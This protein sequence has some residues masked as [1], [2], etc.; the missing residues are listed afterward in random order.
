MAEDNSKVLTPVARRT[1]A[2][3]TAL[4]AYIK[5]L[6]DQVALL[7]ADKNALVADLAEAKGI[8]DALFPEDAGG[9]TGNVI[10]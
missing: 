3:V 2:G 7:T 9:S 5:K 1:E 6:E 8:L 10:G 4:R